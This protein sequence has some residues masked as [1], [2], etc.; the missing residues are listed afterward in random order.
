MT[1]G[2]PISYGF[3]TSFINSFNQIFNFTQFGR[4]LN[5]QCFISSLDFKEKL[6]TSMGSSFAD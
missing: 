6:W 3:S 4:S 5:I 2:F 1:H